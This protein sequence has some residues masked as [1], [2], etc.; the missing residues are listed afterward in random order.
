MNRFDGGVFLENIE[1]F[2]ET[3][4]ELVHRLPETGSGE[5]KWGA[6]LTVRDS[7]AAV[8]FYQGKARDAFGPGR[9]TLKTANLP[10]ITKI[11]S[12]P[13]R[14]DSPLRAEVYL[15]S[16]K[17]FTNLKW[18]TTNPV[19][20]RDAELGLIRLRAH[21]I[22]NLQVVQPILLINSLVGTM[23]SIATEEIEA[24]L[25][26]VIVSRFNDYLGEN[27][28]TILNL[29]G[30]FDELSVQLQKRL[31]LDFAHFGLRLSHLYI[32][33]ITPPDDVQKAM[34]DRARMSVIK[35]MDQFVRMKAAMAMEKA[36]ENQT[37]A[38]AGVGLGLGMMMPAMFSAAVQPA[39]GIA[40]A[41][42]TVVCPDCRTTIPASARFCPLCGHQLLVLSQC[43]S[44]GKNLSPSAR[45][46]S[47]CGTATEQSPA[48]AICPECRAE[49]L[50]GALFCNQCGQR[51]R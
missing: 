24:Y 46:C 30:R 9:Y 31:T 12:I 41:G 32:T 1:W 26:K 40:P 17:Y 42:D 47:R 20:F 19:A 27:L 6:Q 21:G 15:V 43:S 49:N 23:G 45:F 3:G 37:E 48:A 7:Q 44:C 39:A 33:S 5:I 36:A 28:D 18:G 51:Q 2:D 35:D 14:G 8:L 4:Q 13:W 34:D 50:P 11:L 22:F 10:I 29:P 25:K 38:G 16:M